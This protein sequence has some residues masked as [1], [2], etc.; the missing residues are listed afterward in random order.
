MSDP[1]AKSATAARLRSRATNGEIAPLEDEPAATQKG[2]LELRVWLRLLSCS[3]KIENLLSLRLRKEFK[4]S[5]PR[6][7][8]L[9]QLERFPDGLTMSDLS[10]RLM[11]SNGAITGLVDRLASE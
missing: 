6:F 4:I 2:H 9:A 1:I 5:M 8:A 11:V 10:R 7:D 3:V